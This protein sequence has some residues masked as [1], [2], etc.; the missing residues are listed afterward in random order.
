MTN[1]IDGP[2]QPRTPV[3]G[4]TGSASRTESGA[5]GAGGSERKSADTVELTDQANR[6]R[7]LEETLTALPSSDSGRVEAVRQAIA[8][9]RFEINA[10][11]IADGLLDF[12]K[13]IR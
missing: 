13:G 2:S 10:E 4:G 1:R 9:G 8:E 6:L 5:Q 3:A 7:K 12:E 11:R